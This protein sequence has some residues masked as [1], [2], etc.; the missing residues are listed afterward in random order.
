MLVHFPEGIGAV[1]QHRGAKRFYCPLP[2]DEL[3]E[4]LT[5]TDILLEYELTELPF[6]TVLLELFTLFVPPALVVVVCCTVPFAGTGT[7]WPFTVTRTVLS[8]V[9]LELLDTVVVVVEDPFVLPG[10]VL[11]VSLVLPVESAAAELP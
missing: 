4:L 10:T 1:H 2:P 11:G 3:L 8:P 9:P 5:L 6:T 7:S